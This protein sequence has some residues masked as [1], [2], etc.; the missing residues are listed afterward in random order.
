[1]EMGIMETLYLL[2][3]CSL[4]IAAVFLAFFLRAVR[5]GQYDDGV[6]PAMRI[7]YDDDIAAVH[8]RQGKSGSRNA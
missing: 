5:S 6:T 3:G 8:K 7:L 2:I 1:M 4:A